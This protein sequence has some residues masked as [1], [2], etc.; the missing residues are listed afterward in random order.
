MPRRAFL[1]LGLAGVG[2]AALHER[3][4]QYPADYARSC[5]GARLGTG[6]AVRGEQARSAGAD[7]DAW[8]EHVSL[9][10]GRCV[11]APDDVISLHAAVALLS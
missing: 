7:V 8:H 4:R 9:T 3:P 5:R 1:R 10:A 2:G 11:S 6:I